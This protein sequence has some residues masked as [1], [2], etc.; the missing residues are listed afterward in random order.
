MYIL[1]RM[2]LAK[3][4]GNTTPNWHDC[5]S[6][7]TSSFV[8]H[9]HHFPS[10]ITVEDEYT[11]PNV[12]EV[13]FS[14]FLDPWE[15]YCNPSSALVEQTVELFDKCPGTHNFGN[16]DHHVIQHEQTVPFESDA[17]S[18][19]TL[20]ASNSGHFYSQDEHSLDYSQLLQASDQKKLLFERE[21]HSNSDAVQT[22][23]EHS[24][25]PPHVSDSELH[26]LIQNIEQ[27]STLCDSIVQLPDEKFNC[28]P[29]EADYFQLEQPKELECQRHLHQHHL[30]NQQGFEFTHISTVD[31]PENNV[32][33]ESESTLGS[34]KSK[35]KGD[36]AFSNLHNALNPKVDDKTQTQSHISFSV[37]RIPIPC[38]KPTDLQIIPSSTSTI[39][40]SSEVSSSLCFVINFKFSFSLLINL[41]F[42]YSN[43]SQFL[44]HLIYSNYFDKCNPTTYNLIL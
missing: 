8:A 13:D 21:T 40:E 3:A 30:Q 7:P 14:E 42:S 25:S 32:R 41:Q 2:P 4:T 16:L 36:S 28:D 10:H 11:H 29:H 5:S 23:L 44:L 35:G 43:F 34:D 19:N 1:F 9:S 18:D 39:V 22:S 27:I 12:D 20:S 24:I 37:P 38:T 33:I 26:W 6:F 15:N 17:F 31:R